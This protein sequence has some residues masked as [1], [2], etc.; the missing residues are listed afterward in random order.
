MSTCFT[1]YDL[2]MLFCVN[3]FQFSYFNQEKS[4]IIFNYYYFGTDYKLK[5][6]IIY[7]PDWKKKSCQA[8]WC[9]PS[10]QEAEGRW[11]LELE[12]SLDYIASLRTSRDTQRD[13]KHYANEISQSQKITLVWHRVGP[14]RL[15]SNFLQSWKWSW[16]SD[17][18][19]TP[20]GCLE[21]TGKHHQLLSYCPNFEPLFPFH[22]LNQI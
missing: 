16:A 3:T 13:P 6:Q 1:S 5:E 19:A 11:N 15:A 14:M 17:P 18:P 7:L 8:W 4:Y 9:T 22:Y 2:H 10:T 20:P 12:A 21:M